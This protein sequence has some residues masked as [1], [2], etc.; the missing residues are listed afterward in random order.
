MTGDLEK[1]LEMF[2]DPDDSMEIIAE[3]PV[4]KDTH[5]EYYDNIVATYFGDVRKYPLLT[6]MEEQAI[7]HAIVCLRVKMR[8]ILIISPALVPVLHRVSDTLAENFSFSCYFGDLN[9]RDR[10][11]LTEQIQSLPV[12]IENMTASLKSLQK[13][14]RKTRAAWSRRAIRMELIKLFHTLVAKIEPLGFSSEFYDALENELSEQVAHGK[15]EKS[16]I[17]SWGAFQHTQ[18]KYLERCG[19]MVRGNLR[20]VIHVANRYR[21]SGVP[22]LDL[23]QGGNIGL[24]RAV[25]KFEP[26][27]RL[28]FV[29][30]AHWWVRQ[31]ITRC[32][33]EQFRTIRLPNHVLEKKYK[34]LSV[35][36]KMLIE[37]TALSVSAIARRL[38]WKTEDV[39]KLLY[40][41][42]HLVYL[43]Q[44]ITTDGRTVADLIEVPQN[45]ADEVDFENMADLLNNALDMLTEREAYILRLRFGID[46]DHAHS[47]R[48]VGDM[49]GLSRERIRQLQNQALGKLRQPHRSSILKTYYD[50]YV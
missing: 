11:S 50:E 49:L 39:E 27:R 23:I 24:M 20:L 25:E 45:V 16:V 19:E 46:T 17:S 34:L 47:L 5:N 22:F 40:D 31:A 30:Y 44:P 35:V 12:C 14:C 29:T 38:G 4:H 32:I 10:R 36:R 7:G 15:N 13:K 18:K 9:V 2:E 26:F 1:Y 37:G 42:Q 3:D 6:F 21:S 33:A 28:K 41:T 48:E 8:R 43:D